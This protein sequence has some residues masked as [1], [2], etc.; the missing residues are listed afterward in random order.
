MTGVAEIFSALET[1]ETAL[2]FHPDTEEIYIINDY[3]KTGRAWQRAIAGQLDSLQGRVRLRYSE[4]LTME[5]LRDTVSSLSEK[6]IVLLGVYYSDREGRFSTYE[7]TG[8]IISRV[9]PVPLYCLV[10]FNLYE[11]V[12]GGKLISGQ[13]QGR[14]MAEIG[15]RILSGEDP[16]GIPVVKEGANRYMFNYSGLMR[17]GISERELPEGSLIVNRPFSLYREYFVQF[18][19]F[20]GLFSVLI[21]A[22]IGLVVNT[23][24]IRNAEQSLKQ[25]A[26]ATWEGIAIHDHGL[27]INMNG[28][29]LSMF[30][31][32][33][34]DVKD[35]NLIRYIFPPDSFKIVREKI[36]NEAT[37]T[38]EVMGKKKDGTLFPLEIRAKMMDYKRKRVRVTALRDLTQQK[39]IEETLT[40]SQKMQAIGTLAGGIA[41][42]FNNI[43]SGVLGFADLGL[44]ISEP[45]SR[46]REYYNQIQSA[47]KRARELTRQILSFSRQTSKELQPVVFSNIINETLELLRASLPSTI[48]LRKNL[49]E[50]VC[51]LADPVQLQQ[52]IMNLCTNAGLAMKESGGELEI[53]LR[54]DTLR[55]P[56]LSG[57]SIQAGEY[58]RLTVSDT[59]CGMPEDVKKR[60]FE[61]F[62]TTREQGRGTG[63]GLSVV[64][65]II[66][67]MSGNIS[68]YS[69]EGQGSSF[70]ILLP[71]CPRDTAAAENDSEDIPITGGN[72]RILFVDDE[73]Q[74]TELAEKM[75]GSLGYK[76]TAVNSGR[77]ALALFEKSPESYD[78]LIS[79]VT[80][81]EMTGDILVEKI[82][83]IRSDLPVIVCSGYSERH[84]GDKLSALGLSRFVMKPLMMKETAEMIRSVLEGD[85]ELS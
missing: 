76:V 64:H 83:E 50:S 62:F 58:A 29:F 46:H 48:T 54:K 59:G 61:P 24:A 42:D 71:L 70:T 80:M 10:K 65:G 75:L 6:S 79:D 67:S 84:T 52:I 12:I 3:L 56:E 23:L 78:L 66:S 31:L 74:Q 21:I 73:K 47:G 5:E 60:I 20:T 39:K 17:F 49:D 9:C 34:E 30:G 27:L 36:E 63:M 69:D 57:L 28:V 37:D 19:L 26:E 1:V 53:I 68:V 45:G 13:V 77:E 82:R 44:M 8:K 33:M 11:G 40:Q 22:V 14:K 32:S 4:N 35:P 7:E 51:L 38:Y 85:A 81:P 41:H 2:S 72:E 15:L 55:N 25:L 16:S 18:W 43:L